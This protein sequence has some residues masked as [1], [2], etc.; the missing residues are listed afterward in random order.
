MAS[1]N[2]KR[3]REMARAIMK[4]SARKDYVGQTEID[5]HGIHGALERILSLFTLQEKCV[6]SHHSWMRMMS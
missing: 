3:G 1:I 2:E 5:N 4:E 6:M